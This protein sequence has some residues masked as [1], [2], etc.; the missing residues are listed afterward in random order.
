MTH[1]EFSVGSP[2]A[3]ER[4]AIHVPISITALGMTLATLFAIIFVVCVLF[5]LAVPQYSMNEAWAP[6]LPG[7]TWL[8]WT[9]FAIGLVES[10]FYG[11]FFAVLFAPLY[12]FFSGR[13]G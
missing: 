12:N 9:T 8:S 2:V 10:F 7:F 6:L 3:P 11:W 4:S 5:D 13:Y 1:A